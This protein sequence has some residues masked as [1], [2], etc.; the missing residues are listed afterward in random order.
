MMAAGSALGSSAMPT[1]R[2]FLAAA[3]AIAGASLFGRPGTAPAFSRSLPPPIPAGPETSVRLDLAAA[4]RQL[5]QPC[6]DGHILPMWTFTD[7]AAP[8]IVR[9][10]LGQRLETHLENRLTRPGEHVSIHWHGI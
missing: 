4:E 7:A 3:A 10:K 6:F 5:T 2:T 8:P 1:R 9:L